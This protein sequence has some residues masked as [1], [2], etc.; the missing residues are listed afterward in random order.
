M[1][2]LGLLQLAGRAVG[3]GPRFG[4]V[5]RYRVMR[6]RRHGP[7]ADRAVGADGQLLSQRDGGV[8][9]LGGSQ[10]PPRLR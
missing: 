9:P 2:G 10:V 7:Q 3:R 1:L 4:Q 6:Q 8:G 5:G